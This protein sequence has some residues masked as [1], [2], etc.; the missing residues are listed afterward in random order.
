MCLGQAHVAA[1]PSPRGNAAGRRATGA[2]PPSGSTQQPAEGQE[3]RDRR[4]RCRVVSR[5]RLLRRWCRGPKCGDRDRRPEIGQLDRAL[6]CRC[7]IG[8]HEVARTDL[9]AGSLMAVDDRR[10]VLRYAMLPTDVVR[11]SGGC[12]SELHEH[13]Q[14]RQAAQEPS[15]PR[16]AACSRKPIDHAAQSRPRQERPSDANQVSALNGGGLSAE[17]YQRAAESAHP[18]RV[19]RRGCRSPGRLRTC[20]CN[21]RSTGA[22]RLSTQPQRIADDRCRAQAHRQRGDHR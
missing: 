5:L 19:A 9:V 3:S 10:T 18:A 14:R 7:L 8:R 1:R 6:A 17:R 13:H 21:G 20:R 15:R 2:D 4:Q 11:A 12:S 22:Q 16:R